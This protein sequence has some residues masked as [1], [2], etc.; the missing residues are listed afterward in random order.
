MGTKVY[1]SHNHYMDKQEISARMP[2]LLTKIQT[3]AQEL[4]FDAL[5]VSDTDLNEHKAYLLDWLQKGAHGTMRFME[6][7]FEKRTQPEMLLSDTLRIVTVRMNYLVPTQIAADELLKQTD[8]AYI[9]R[10]ALGRDYHKLMRKRLQ[11]L[12]DKIS[13]EVGHF[14]YRA[15]VDS[16]PV[17]E[18]ALAQK[19]GLGWVGKHTLNLNK[20]A[21]SFY[22]LGELY[23]DLP[24][25]VSV[26]ATQ[27]CGSCQK[28]IDICPS[29]AIVA[30]FKLDA[31]RCIAYLT[32]EHHGPIPVEY[33]KTIGNR[34]FGC[35]D[36]QLVCPWNHF[37]QVTYDAALQV[38]N[39]L[40]ASRLLD[41]F[42]WSE[43]TFLERTRASVLRR[44]G[45][46]RWLGNI[47]IAL[48]NAPYDAAIV[49]A[50]HQAT[51]H[52]NA[53]VREH[54]QWALDEQLAQGA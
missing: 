13:A 40:D 47:A 11:K 22:F 41:L 21:G 53:V 38:R 24:L 37:A 52:N 23:T 17:M 51:K 31:R 50:L 32:I 19:S 44:L 43:E 7:H 26:P 14:N 45:Y 12:A 1:N 29:Q 3:W 48:G 35:D 8:M 42:T 33:R 5:G 39:N 15:F 46:T 34:V 25:P 16:A 36:C 27:H 9:A 6:N 28:C 10:Y 18:K 2:A 30:P 49:T 4:G 54:A 20:H